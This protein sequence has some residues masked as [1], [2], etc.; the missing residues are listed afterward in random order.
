MKRL[1]FLA[2]AAGLLVLPACDNVRVP[3]LNPVDEARPD[4]ASGNYT[5]EDLLAS[6]GEADENEPEGNPAPTVDRA[7]PEDATGA[8]AEPLPDETGSAPAPVDVT[9]PPAP[10]ALASLNAARCALP[11]DQPPTLTVA[12]IAGAT[13]SDEPVFGTEAVNALAGSLN[14]FPGIVKLEPR[15]TETS[16][17][18]ASGHCGAT[19]IG[20][21]WFVT[22]AHCID[23]P[24]EE[25]RLIGG[26]ENLRSPLARVTNATLAICHGGYQGTANGYAND[27]AVIRLTDDQVAAIGDVPVARFGPTV[28]PLAPSNYPTAE[29]AGWGITQFGGHLSNDLLTTPLRITAT[30]PAA[31]IVASANGAGPCIGD[32]GG[33]LYVTETDGSKTVVGVLSVVEQ[34]RETGQFCAGDYNGRYTNLQGFSDW[35]TSVI[36]ACE[37][38]L[39]SC[40]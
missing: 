34:N 20:Q 11:A 16:G 1:A 23:Q 30:G 25:L 6:S 28:K 12:S 24:Y 31:I 10:P 9:L 39:E 29:M 15:R 17:A 7:P 4:T 32:S 27:V 8:V 5:E 26:A 21:N 22:A 36:N 40:R 19:R 37:T 2:A 18:I 35:I 14:A 13:V 38:D 33:P 3:V